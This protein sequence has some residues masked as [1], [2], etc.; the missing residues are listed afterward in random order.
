M[1]RKKTF[2]CISLILL[3]AGCMNTPS[4][5]PQ[6]SDISSTISAHIRPLQT[7]TY[8]G[9]RGAIIFSINQLEDRSLKDVCNRIIKTFAEKEIPVDVSITA[10]K[11]I[12]EPDYLDFLVPYSDVGLIDVNLDGTDFEWLVTDSPYDENAHTY[13]KAQLQHDSSYINTR[14]G[15]AP[16][17]CVFPY[18]RFNEYNYKILQDA[19]FS[20]VSSI[21]KGD[22]TASRQPVSWSGKDDDR[23]LYRL[24]IVAEVSYP[25][26]TPSLE[27]H[28]LS[29][30]EDNNKILDKIIKGTTQFGLAVVS[31]Q[32]RSLTGSDGRIDSDKIQQLSRLIDLSGQYGE[33]VTYNGWLRYAQNYI[34]VKQSGSRILPDYNGGPT[35][36][37]RLDDVSKGWHEDADIEL[38]K[39]FK[40]NGVPLDCGVISNASGT[41]S[42][43]LPW[44]K[45]Y[46]DEGSVGISVHGF[47]WTYYQLDTSQSGLAYEFIKFKLLKA[48]DQYLNYFGVSPVAFTVPTDFYDRSGYQA[49]EEAGFKIFSTQSAVEPHPSNIPVDFDGRKDPKGMYR[50]PTAS[51]VCVWENEKFTTVYDVSKLLKLNNYCQYYE[52]IPP[53]SLDNDFGYMVCR[54]L[55]ILNV[56][57][58]GLHPSAFVDDEGKIYE[59]R[60]KEV[61]S[62]IK[63]VK[64]FASVTTFEQWYNYHASER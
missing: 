32:P 20:I 63:W 41:N 4:S 29:P 26:I 42:Y 25:S 60:L 8:S 38:I 13:L 58:I 5:V 61:D 14:F 10:P 28:T 22:F 31:I 50:L 57:V 37:F 49:V 55:K 16:V 36:I 47:D 35:V 43:E 6:G 12:K 17:A 23:G 44:L 18:E 48:R 7:H 45:Q 52:T 24:P 62:I 56:A 30:G 40:S 21:E 15:S 54:E 53:V 39:L 19:G 9:D 51:D 3:F 59:E 27:A 34:G 1:V 2:Y 64:T 46:V 11:D 33:I